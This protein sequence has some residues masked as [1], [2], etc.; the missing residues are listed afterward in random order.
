V[1]IESEELCMLGGIPCS[2]PQKT[3]LDFETR[4]ILMKKLDAGRGPL[5]RF[6]SRMLI[7]IPVL[8]C[9]L[10]GTAFAQRSPD[11]MP[12]N[13]PSSSEKLTQ[14]GAV[15]LA[16]RRNRSQADLTRGMKPGL[17]VFTTSLSLCLV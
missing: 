9:V 14:A 8:L 4:R 15:G 11:S 3:A 1:F 10:P 2:H 17:P 7:G 13:A 12:S 6:L 5:E 16:L